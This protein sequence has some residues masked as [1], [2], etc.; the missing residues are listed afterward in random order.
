MSREKIKIDKEDFDKFLEM[1]KELTEKYNSLFNE[2]EIVKKSLIEK[3]IPQ[4]EAKVGAE[5]DSAFQS[6]EIRFI[7]INTPEDLARH[8]VQIQEFRKKLESLMRE[9]KVAQLNATI[10]KR[11]WG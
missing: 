3:Q 9:Y 5:K 4:S 11:L 10:L 6:F 1:S 2:V 7:T 8:Q